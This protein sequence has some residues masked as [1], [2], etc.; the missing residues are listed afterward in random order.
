[1][2]DDPVMDVAMEAASNQ[3]ARMTTSNPWDYARAVV[4]ELRKAG[5]IDPARERW[6]ADG[7]PP[8]V[9]L[10]DP[11]T[12]L[13]FLREMA[14]AGAQ[15]HGAASEEDGRSGPVRDIVFALNTIIDSIGS[16]IGE[17]SP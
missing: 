8:V 7:S 16:L 3:L 9:K 4:V 2:T 12:V 15:L 11:T 6:Q 5:M 14:Q 1:M 10:D 13:Y 17:P